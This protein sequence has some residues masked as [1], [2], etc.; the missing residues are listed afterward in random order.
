MSD[1]SMTNKFKSAVIILIFIAIISLLIYFICNCIG[2]Q[3]NLIVPISVIISVIS[4]IISYYNSD[5]IVLSMNNAKPA[6]P[7]Q[8][9]RMIKILE[10]LCAKANIEMPRLYVVEDSSPNAFATGRNPKHAVIC[11]TTGILSRLE[12]YELEGVLA[13]ELSHVKNFDIRLQAVATVFVGFITILSDILLRSGLR[14]SGRKN[15]NNSGGIVSIVIFIVGLALTILSP[16]VA[17][18]MQL[19][20]SRKREFLADS[21]AAELTG[22]PQGLINALIKIS[23]DPQPLEVA[24]KATASMYIS[25]PF[26]GKDAQKLLNKLYATHP[27]MDERIEALRNLK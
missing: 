17:Q 13:H 5:K 20:L 10:N 23:S 12:D 16:I 26:K 14:S 22:N 9:Q 7:E 8:N 19:A 27:P 18:L 3:S 21:S 25:N 15:D 2:V 6:T 11:V 1:W 4:S 24:N